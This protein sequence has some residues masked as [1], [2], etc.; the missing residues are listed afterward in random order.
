M[1]RSRMDWTSRLVFP[2]G[3]L[4]LIL[5]AVPNVAIACGHCFGTSVNNATTFGITMAM[6]GLLGFLGV[7]WGGIGMFVWNVRK[8]SEMLE[9]DDWMVTE[10]GEIRSR[11]DN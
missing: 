3:L 1:L 10:D 2:V 11:E 7:V 5:G 8:R 9:P 6:L 4:T